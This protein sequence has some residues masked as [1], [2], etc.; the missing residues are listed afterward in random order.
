MATKKRVVAG[1]CLEP[2]KSSMASRIPQLVMNGSS[3]DASTSGVGSAD[4]VE[5]GPN[6]AGPKII[7]I[8]EDGTFELPDDDMPPDLNE[9]SGLAGIAAAVQPPVPPTNPKVDTSNDEPSLMDQMMADA[10]AARKIVKDKAVDEEKRVKK[11]F[12]TGMKKGFFNSAP[13]KKK[14]STK[15][16]SSGGASASGPSI[17]TIRRATAAELKKEKANALVLGEVQEAMKD[18]AGPM[19]NALAKTEDWVTPDLMKKF[20]TNPKL[21]RGLTDPKFQAALQELQKDPKAAMLKFQGDK[22][23]TAFLQEFCQT[24]GEHFGHIGA[25]QEKEQKIKQAKAESTSAAKSK[26]STAAA[27]AAAAA[28]VGKKAAG[29]GRNEGI[30]TVPERPLSDAAMKRAAAA[31]GGKPVTQAPSVSHEEQ[32]QM[33]NILRNEELRELLMD[34]E[35]QQVMQKCQEPGRLQFFM[36]DPKWGPKI[37]K[38]SDFG[39][40]RFVSKGSSRDCMFALGRAT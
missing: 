9:P 21:A 23:L 25:Q 26:K 1:G 16:S 28:D 15:K 19:A 37:R 27:A 11:E 12:G 17:P 36:S 10:N 4:K 6:L 40:V 20:A 35:M 7:E 13:P 30:P 24:M 32:A 2:T 3:N 14:G 39:L 34:P 33:D 18:A 29:L 22:E 5:Q 8:S 38:L 31:N